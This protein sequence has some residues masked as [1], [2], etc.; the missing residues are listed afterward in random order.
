MQI[1]IVGLGLIGGSLGLDLLECGHTLHGV[2]QKPQT[3]ETAIARGAVHTASTDLRSLAEFPV[4]VIFICTPIPLTLP[5]LEQLTQW[6]PPSVLITDVASIKGSLVTAALSL[7]PNFVGGHPMAGTEAQGIQAAVRH[8]FQDRPYVLTPHAQTASASIE[9]LSGLIKD[10]QARMILADPFTHDQAVA[11][12][13][14]LP[15]M[16]SASLIAA[17]SR[18]SQSQVLQL[19]QKLASSGFRDTSRVGG[20]NPDLGT[21]MAQ[22]NRQALLQTLNLYK[23]ELDQVIHYIENQS[24]GDLHQLLQATHQERQIFVESEH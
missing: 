20:G 11:W 22:H 10:L 18:E 21:A 24:W 23:Q 13:S 19:A 7:W 5:T 16:I 15:V 2:S 14:H 1:G 9:Q 4:E 12:I 17:C 8:L 3:C 6:L